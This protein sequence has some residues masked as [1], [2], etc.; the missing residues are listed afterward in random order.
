MGS[1][2]LGNLHIDLYQSGHRISGR[3]DDESL[4][5]SPSPGTCA[6]ATSRRASPTSLA[7]MV[8]RLASK[9][10]ALTAT[11]PWPRQFRFAHTFN[12]DLNPNFSVAEAIGAVL[13]D[14][15]LRVVEFGLAGYPWFD[16]W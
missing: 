7:M 5:E 1:D 16:G 8:L 3:L 15:K 11:T 12:T 14:G 2:F 6:A 9:S 10:R 4:S 13:Q